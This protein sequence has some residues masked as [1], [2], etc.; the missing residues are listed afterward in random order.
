M[1]MNQKSL[2]Q[3]NKYGLFQDSTTV[4]S[5]SNPDTFTTQ[6]TCH[7]CKVNGSTGI[8][9]NGCCYLAIEEDN[10]LIAEYIPVKNKTVTT[11]TG[12]YDRISGTLNTGLGTHTFNALN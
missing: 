1:G 5:W 8:R 6:Q 7:I 10:V 4:M 12:L 2:L 9:P 3:T 11:E